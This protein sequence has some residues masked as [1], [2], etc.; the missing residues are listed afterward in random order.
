MKYQNLVN[1]DGQVILIAWRKRSACR[2]CH[3][4]HIDLEPD[5]SEG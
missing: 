2:V 1:N 4:C 3:K 5:R